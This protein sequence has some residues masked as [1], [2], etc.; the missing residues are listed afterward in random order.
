[1]SSGVPVAPEW[2]DDRLAGSLRG[3]HRWA[4]GR[5]RAPG[6][7]GGAARYGVIVVTLMV[8]SSLPI[9]AAIGVS[10][11]SVEG[12]LSGGMALS[13]PGA[14]TPFIARPSTGP[15]VLVP[16][17]TGVAVPT[18]PPGPDAAG[19]CPPSVPSS[20][21][22]RPVRPRLAREELSLD[23]TSGPAWAAGVEGTATP[24]PDPTPDP[25]PTAPTGPPPRQILVSVPSRLLVGLRPAP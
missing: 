2:A 15:V 25:T 8:T 7:N 22:A 3:V 20:A 10:S 13:A 12:G 24:A 1:M 19:T 18:M 6:L 4:A 14:T 5:H 9:L 17:P 23:A 16:L 21:P 11:A